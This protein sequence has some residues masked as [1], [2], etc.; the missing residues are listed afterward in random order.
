M[1]RYLVVSIAFVGLLLTQ[2]GCSDSVRPGDGL[3]RLQ[4]ALPV[5]GATAVSV[6]DSVVLRFSAEVS[7]AGLSDAV[8]LE[9]RGRPV[10]VEVVRRDRRT[11]VV[12]PAVP[13]DFG[14]EYRI[15]L[16]S[17]LRS[18]SGSSPEGTT[19]WAFSTRG[20]AP[21]VPSRDSLRRHLEALAHDS[22]RGR[23][24]GSQDE[25]RAARY[26][27]GRLLSYDLQVP[28]RGVIQPFVTVGR[29]DSLL[30]SRNVMAEVAGSGPLAGEWI[31][32]G[33]HYDHIGY[34]GLADETLGP[35]NGADDNA[36]GTALILE[37]ARLLQD[38]VSG[39][40]TAGTARRSVLFIGFGAEEEGL[41]GS[42]HYVFEAPEVP[43]ART[44]AMMNFDMVGR[45]RNELLTVS[46]QGT[47]EVW[48]TVLADA[49]APNLALFRPDVSHPSGSD[50]ACF[51]RWGIPSLSFFTGFHDEY[52]TPQD[53]V[54]LIDFSGLG[55]VGEL[56]IRI[57]ARLMV[58]PEAPS[59]T[60]PWWSPGR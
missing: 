30:S 52:H 41:L 6:L 2:S 56:G 10:I 43:L 12:S 35:N 24:S 57:L 58:M 39:D 8:R 55:R 3:F 15:V 27:E 17:A 46:G 42:C 36:S 40:G 48:P 54:D 25:L 26:L 22:M 53:D 11:V 44:A 4:S 28:A 33:A 60:G 18:R 37:M 29:G 31:V 7:T 47:A 20:L 38:W 19:S 32:V 13:L 50:H 1:R 9:A 51:W 16:T 45:L 14:T 23:R 5:P 34:R 21:P 49:N 59:F